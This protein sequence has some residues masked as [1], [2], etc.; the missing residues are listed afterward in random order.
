MVSHSYNMVT[1]TFSD[2]FSIVFERFCS[3]RDRS[4]DIKKGWPLTMSITLRFLARTSNKQN[5]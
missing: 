1:E 3:L 5:I 2:H 4:N